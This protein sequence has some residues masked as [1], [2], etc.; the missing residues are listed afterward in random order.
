MSSFQVSVI[1]LI[2]NPIQDYEI[3]FRLRIYK[4]MFNH[5]ISNQITEMSD[6]E[7]N[8]QDFYCALKNSQPLAF[9]C[10]LS[11]VIA[12]FATP[13]KYSGIHTDAVI[14]SFMF[15]FSFISSLCYQLIFVKEGE[16]RQYVRWTVYFFLIIGIIQL[17]RIA[18]GF[19]STIPQIMSFVIGWMFLAISLAWIIPFRN[20]IKQLRLEHGKIPNDE[21][22][23]LIIICI[24]MIFLLFVSGWMLATAFSI[25]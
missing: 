10:S 20:L 14:A 13:E 25:I 17:V 8:N 9:L 2:R 1:R 24:A 22:P 18:G 4:Y 16:L 5:T 7:I 21:K 3:L 12:I 11:I 19:S 23:R 6:K 15:I